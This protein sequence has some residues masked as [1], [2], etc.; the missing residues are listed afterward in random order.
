MQQFNISVMRLL[1]FAI[2]MSLGFLLVIGTGS[3]LTPTA[4]Q[5]VN[6]ERVAPQL[7]EQLP[8]F[9]KANDYV[10]RETGEVETENTLL[11][12]LIRYH[13]FVKSR[14]IQYRLD[15]KLTLADY[16]G[17][18]DPIQVANYPGASDLTENPAR[19]DIE[20]IRSLN[21]QQRNQLVNAIAERFNPNATETTPQTPVNEPASGSNAPQRPNLPPAQGGADLL[22]F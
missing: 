12:R 13:L 22:R 17:V 3:L 9:P 8:D 10:N 5:F 7:Y 4:A 2:A 11:S 15:W 21:R 18:Y 14:P 20:L 1:R 16:L 6:A 19:H